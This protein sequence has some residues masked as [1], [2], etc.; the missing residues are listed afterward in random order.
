VRTAG[1][2]RELKCPLC[3]QAIGAGDQAVH[4]M[5]GRFAIAPNRLLRE[6]GMTV[7]WRRTYHVDCAEAAGVVLEDLP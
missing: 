4:V 7:R 3:R 5:A 2:R 1:P 6:V